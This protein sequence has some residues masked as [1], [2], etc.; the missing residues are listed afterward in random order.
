MTLNDEAARE[1]A[2]VVHDLARRL[3]PQT[4]ALARVCAL[5]PTTAAVLMIVASHPGSTVREISAR[6]LLQPSNASAAVAELCRRGLAVKSPD[7]ADRRRIRV[8]PTPQ[9]FDEGLRVEMAWAELYARALAKL[10]PADAQSLRLALPAL[11]ALDQLLAAIDSEAGPPGQGAIIP[12]DESADGRQTAD[13]PPPP[14][15]LP[16]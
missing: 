13:R 15:Q 4:L 1:L 16:S 6:G 3:K 8:R 11:R 12:Q 2:I 10:D 7:P 9:A 5:A 14:A